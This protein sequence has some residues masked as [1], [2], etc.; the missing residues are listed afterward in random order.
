MLSSLVMATTLLQAVPQQ[1]SQTWVLGGTPG[2]EYTMSALGRGTDAAGATLTLR[3]TTASARAVGSVSASTPA[4]TFRLRRVR[5]VADIDVRDAATGAAPWILVEGPN[6]P[7]SMDLENDQTVK[8]TGTGHREITVYVPANATRLLF[9]LFL[10]GPG[11]ATARGLHLVARPVAA[12]NAPLG[13][14]AQRE[15]DSAW[16]LVRANSLW[17]DT[18]TW[19][20]VEADVRAMAAGAESVVEVY[21]AIQ[22]L[23]ARL[24]DHHSFLTKPSR[25]QAFRSGGAENPKPVIRVLP[26]AVGYVSVPGF[27]GADPTAALDYAKR[28][29]D[30]LASVMPASSC[31]WVIDVR[32]NGGGN[33]WP[34]L[35]GL[36]P[37]VGDAGLG[38]FITAAG[39]QTM[40]HAGDE[41]N[42]RPPPVLA[43]LESA[44]VAVLTGPRTASSGEVVTISFRG[45]P[46]TRSFGLPTAGQSTANR[47]YTLPDSSM[48]FLTVSVEADRTGRRYG[49]KI[50]PDETIQPSPK[51]STEDAQLARAVAWLLSQPNCGV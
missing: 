43:S 8:G 26:D 33:M 21:P 19:S 23:L 14:S 31:R 12:T 41:V 30:S 16:T 6:G 44:Y 36:R 27:V 34:M 48:I 32:G 47:D 18:V 17:R 15:L 38:S 10:N 49:E 20:K 35:G 24:G 9:G 45:R 29:Q 42:V 7:M 40:W 4:D 5:I 28:M 46:R 25:A 1:V 22:L 51:G 3:S 37:F 11:E 50:E 13:A 39:N 2:A